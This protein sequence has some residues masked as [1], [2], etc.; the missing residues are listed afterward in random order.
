MIYSCM[1][2]VKDSISTEDINKD[3]VTWWVVRRLQ[4][5]NIVA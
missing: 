1:K 3:F 4:R 2:I 5:D